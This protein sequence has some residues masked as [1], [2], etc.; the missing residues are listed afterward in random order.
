MDNDCSRYIMEELHMFPVHNLRKEDIVDT[1]ENQ[2]RLTTDLVT[3]YLFYIYLF[4]F[5]K[6]L[7]M[8]C[9]A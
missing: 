6:D 5:L 9:L 3:F 1:R 4:I 7:N 8:V 2:Q